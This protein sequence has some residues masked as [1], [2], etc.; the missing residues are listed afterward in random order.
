MHE[1]AI[2]PPKFYRPF[3]AF[4]A[5][6]YG[7]RNSQTAAENMNAIGRAFAA[8][9]LAGSGTLVFDSPGTCL[10][11]AQSNP[12]QAGTLCLGYYAGSNLRFV[13]EN[14]TILRAADNQQSGTTQYLFGF[15][16]KDRTKITFEGE[17]TIDLNS[18]GQSGWTGGYGQQLGGHIC[19]YATEAGGGIHDITVEG[20][21]LL[22]TFGNPV[23]LGAL[24]VSNQA[25][26]TRC[27]ARD[28][29]CRVLGEGP[30][31]IGV[32]DCGIFGGTVDDSGSTSLG[33]LLEFSN[34]IDFKCIGVTVLGTGTN[35]LSGSALDCFGSKR[36]TISG[37]VFDGPNGVIDFDD[38][39]GT[40]TC[41][42][43]AVSN[44]VFRNARAGMSAAP[45]G[46]VAFSNNVWDNVGAAT[47]CLQ[48]LSTNAGSKC[49]FVGDKFLTCGSHIV[50]RGQ[51][52][53][54][55]CEIDKGASHAFYWN[56]VAGYLPALRYLG[57]RINGR[58]A[59]GSAIAVQSIASTDHA[60]SA[61]FY[62]VDLTGN[63]GGVSTVVN[64]GSVRNIILDECTT[65]STTDANRPPQSLGTVAVNGTIEADFLLMTTGRNKS[66]ATSRVMARV[67]ALTGSPSVT[68]SVGSVAGS[69]TN[70]CPSQVLSPTAVGQVFALS[71]A[72]IAGPA[73]NSA[74][75]VRV[76]SAAGT[77]CKFQFSIEGEEQPEYM[78]ATVPTTA[79]VT[80]LALFLGRESTYWAD[81]AGT[82][83]AALGDR[84]A[85]WDTSATGLPRASQGTAGARPVRQ[86]AGLTNFDATSIMELVNAA[87]TPTS[88]SIVGDFTAYF[89][90][91]LTADSNGWFPVVNS[92]GTGGFLIAQG[93]GNVIFQTDAAQLAVSFLTLGVTAS[94]SFLF[95]F[96]RA[97][98]V[99][100][101]SLTGRATDYSLGTLAGTVTLNRVQNWPSGMS[102]NTTHRNGNI[103]VCNA[104]LA[105]DGTEDAL[106]RNY[107]YESSAVRLF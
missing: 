95:R 27:Y 70:V 57:G 75:Y 56:Q 14:G 19:G 46:S 18:Q 45:S 82:L 68:L 20:L 106:I 9:A 28:L 51:A 89:T 16:F 47:A 104:A 48:F 15:A 17:G 33:D 32:T 30:Q 64:T 44:N 100:T 88:V 87:G 60:P 36:G 63:A 71:L 62:R 26:N 1:N 11:N 69:Y 13:V 37:N 99:V 53:F 38:G 39:L 78:A 23:N 91:Y 29:R 43:I 59:N 103:I 65:N 54:V 77:A 34:C 84:V 107:L 98:G 90:G 93:G 79:N 2:Y 92:T 80:S 52:E 85:R 21:T 3:R 42:A 41:D 94:G 4:Y 7:F 49:T 96:K 102:A 40:T 74:V 105:N 73:A 55:G 97:S 66:L 67:T 12:Y 8:I 101:L 35:S 61:T 25:I 24:G 76:T 58:T 72:T 83:A 22:N 86:S 81:T 50:S 6:T 31:F 10:G 5:T